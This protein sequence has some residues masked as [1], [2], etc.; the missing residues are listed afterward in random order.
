MLRELKSVRPALQAPFQTEVSFSLFVGNLEIE[1]DDQSSQKIRIN[2]LAGLLLDKSDVMLFTGDAKCW[3]CPGG[4]V[5]PQTG[6]S[7]CI[8][9]KAGEYSPTTTKCQKCHEG[10]EI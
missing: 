3:P 7:S 8:R 9:C 1:S 2:K 5:Q 10:S 4:S 6:S